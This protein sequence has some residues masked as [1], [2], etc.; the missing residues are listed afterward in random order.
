M[1]LAQALN[2][3]A[4]LN[5]R[6]AQLRER[7]MDNAKVQEGAEPDEDPNELL[8]ELERDCSQLMELM[9]R[10]NRTNV[11]TIRDGKSLAQRLAQRDVLTLKLSI[12][13]DFLKESSQKC[14]RFTH[15]EIRVFSTVPVAEKQKQ[16]D[17]LSKSLRELDN[18]IQGL[19]WTTELS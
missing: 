2:D 11:Q 13:R 9:E 7:L 10:I 12:L 8:E 15:T 5:R 4:D 16:V 17:Q 14:D 18:E 19:N 3:R 6:I 1:K